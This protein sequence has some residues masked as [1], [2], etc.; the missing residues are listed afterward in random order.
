MWGPG[1]RGVLLVPPLFL[2]GVHV[3]ELLPFRAYRYNPAVAGELAALVCPPYDVIPEGHREA[4]HRRHP[5]NAIRLTLGEDLPGDDA[6]ENRYARSAR[7]FAEWVAK[8]VLLREP[9]H[10]FYLSQQTFQDPAGTERTRTGLIAAVRLEPYGSGVVFPHEETF[11]RPKEDR[12]RLMRA[13]PANLEQILVLCDGPADPFRRLLD[14]VASTGPVADFRDDLGSRSRFWVIRDRDAGAALTS[15]FRGR[16]LFIADGHH[17]YETALLFREEMRAADP[18][19]PEIQARRVYNYVTMHLVHTEDPGLLILPTHRLVA[20]FPAGDATAIRR[21]LE[22]AGHLTSWRL[23]AAGE[24][25]PALLDALQA[26][27]EGCAV[28]CAW[29]AEEAGLLRMPDPPGGA[30]VDGLDAAQAQQRILA[31]LIAR[32]GAS[33]EELVSYTRD[34]PAALAAVRQG[35]QCLALFLRPPTVQQVM[36]VALAGGRMPQ[37][38]T[39]F[40]PKVLTG[41]LFQRA[42]PL[43]MAEEA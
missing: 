20:P 41:L 23:G 26:V 39:Y 18:V 32:A 22:A 3:A 5:H 27:R 11:A 13:M 25:L 42:E 28:A 31:P 12:L 14:G 1:R 16:R 8:G 19:P 24:G 29:G 37:K 33:A 38:T 34:A 17:R 35:K 7:H 6:R 15:A 4:L 21:V 40:Y 9:T 2:E 43:A 10:A 36:T 30:P